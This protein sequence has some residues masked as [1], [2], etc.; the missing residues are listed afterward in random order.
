M[1][2]LLIAKTTSQAK[3][4]SRLN[5]QKKIRKISHGLYVDDLD[6]SLEKLIQSNWMDIVSHVVSKGILSYRTAVELKPIPFENK[7]IVFV[8]SSYTK[9]IQLPGLIIKVLSGNQADYLE[10]VLPTLARSNR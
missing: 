9:T 2:N 5:R 8:T 1:P 10:Q 3:Q 7:T 4:L 6:A